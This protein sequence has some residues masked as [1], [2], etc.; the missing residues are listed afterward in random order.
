MD[1]EALLLRRSSAAEVGHSLR[2][3]LAGLDS[4]GRLL[5]CAYYG[6]GLTLARIAAIEGV[7]TTT[8]YRRIGAAARW[9][10]A[11]V[12]ADLSARLDLSP[13]GVDG[14][15]GLVRSDLDLGISQWLADG[16]R[17]GRARRS[18]E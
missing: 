9:V 1:P 2:R 13:G 8:V 3:A 11:R 15:I 4:R 5:L 16:R 18:P 12:R 7:G 6:D 17:A 10:L 14:V